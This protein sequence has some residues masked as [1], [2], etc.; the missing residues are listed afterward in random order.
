M[1]RQAHTDTIVQA[2]EAGAV[3]WQMPWHAPE[4]PLHRPRNVISGMPYKG[5]NILVLRAEAR[6]RNY[7]TNHWATYRQWQKLGAQVR[8][9]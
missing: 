2:I 6:L 3:T 1:R 9:G 4:N 8:K 5:V 7:P